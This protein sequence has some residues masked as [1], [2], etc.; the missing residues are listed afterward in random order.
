MLEEK[1]EKLTANSSFKNRFLERTKI[2]NLIKKSIFGTKFSFIF[3]GRGMS[4]GKADVV[5][6]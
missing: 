1:E 4:K 3:F 6:G 2:A 5:K